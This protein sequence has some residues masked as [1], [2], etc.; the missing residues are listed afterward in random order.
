MCGCKK[1][2][3]ND[4]HTFIDM[5]FRSSWARSH[6]ACPIIHPRRLHDF[7]SYQIQILHF[8]PAFKHLIAYAFVAGISR[9]F[10]PT[11]KIIRY[12][13]PR[14]RGLCIFDWTTF[15]M[16]ASFSRDSPQNDRAW[17][18]RVVFGRFG[19]TGYSRFLHWPLPRSSYRALYLLTAASG[20]LA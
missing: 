20:I 3:T 18:Q 14:S 13:L 12:F 11:F 1:C 4:R 10:L 17:I 8:N 16:I 7:Y 6:S 15:V 2:Q 9:V 19:T 5:K